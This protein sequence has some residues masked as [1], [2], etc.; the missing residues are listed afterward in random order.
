MAEVLKKKTEDKYDLKSINKDLKK[1]EK[2][3]KK[4]EKPQ[5]HKTVKK[6]SEKK[7][8]FTKI[9]DYFNGVGVEFKRI[10]WP[11]KKDMVKY[12][13]ATVFFIIFFGIFF[14]LIDIIFA[15]IRSLF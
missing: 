14:Y 11:S 7:G 2:N 12:S 5:T 8:F 6:T 9:K 4:K 3:N 13:I 15:F 1:K 10:H